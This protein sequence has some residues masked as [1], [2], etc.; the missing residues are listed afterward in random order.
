MAKYRKIPMRASNI[1]DFLYQ[2][3]DPQDGTVVSNDFNIKDTQNHPATPLNSAINIGPDFGGNPDFFSSNIVQ[4]P[5]LLQNMFDGKY[6]TCYRLAGHA[7][8]GS[9][10]F[11]NN[12]NFCQFTYDFGRPINPRQVKITTTC[13]GPFSFQF[14]FLNDLNQPNLTYE[15][16]LPGFGDPDFVGGSLPYYNNILVQD[17]GTWFAGIVTPF[18][19]DTFNNPWNYGRDPLL[20]PAQL[21]FPGTMRLVDDFGTSVQNLSQHVK[22]FGGH[23]HATRPM[24]DGFYDGYQFMMIRLLGG[25]SANAILNN[26]SVGYGNETDIVGIEVFEEVFEKDFNVEFDDALLDLHGW[27]NTRYYG[28]KLTSRRINKFTTSG[29]NTLVAKGRFDG[30]DDLDELADIFI[31]NNGQFQDKGVTQGMLLKNVSTGEMETIKNVLSQTELQTRS[32]F[33]ENFQAQFTGQGGDGTQERNLYEI[34][35]KTNYPDWKGDTSF[36]KN[37]V[38]ENQTTALYI[39]NTVV[40][41]KEDEQFAT[42]KGH[43]YVGINKILL[44]NKRDNTVQILDKEAEGFDEFN[45]FITKDFPAGSSANCKVIDESIANNLKSEYHVKMNKG[46]LLKSFNYKFNGQIEPDENGVNG[47]GQT[48]DVALTKNTM[49]L[50]KRAYRTFDLQSSQGMSPVDDANLVGENFHMWGVDQTQTEGVINSGAPFS[51]PID[52]TQDP[53]VH[54]NLGNE[55][56][57]FTFASIIDNEDIF[58][59]DTNLEGPEDLLPNIGPMFNSSS[60]IK[61][62]Y[63]T[64]FHTRRFGF[65]NDEVESGG[66]ASFTNTIYGQTV[67][68][69]CSSSLNYSIENDVELYC[70]FLEGDKDFAPGTN[71]ERSISTFQID[72]QRTLDKLRFST[73]EAHLPGANTIP[74]LNELTFKGKRDPKFLPTINPFFTFSTTQYYSAGWLDSSGTGAP[75]TVKIPSDNFP[76]EVF[77]IVTSLFGYFTLNPF[78]PEENE[79][80]G[81]CYL[82]AGNNGQNYQVGFSPGYVLNQTQALLEGTTNV[83]FK[84]ENFYS[85]SIEAKFGKTGCEAFQ[86]DISFLDRDHTLIMDIDKPTELFDGI[87]DQGLVIIPEFLDRDIR[88]NVEFYLQKAGIVEATTS[89]TSPPSPDL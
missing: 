13:F 29:S 27:R 81:S 14:Y 62:K 49:F 33:N 8:D 35:K 22:G 77:P 31:D 54:D 9:S 12:D 84:P 78:N 37:P 41:G 47:F 70:T 46:Y 69:L 30:I 79:V 2:F 16:N 34:Y 36:G 85:G 51:G 3:I 25:D 86:Y 50:Y 7:N 28:S 65:L 55:E 19:G 67:E 68:F 87:G 4:S 48:S 58:E 10:Y 52:L 56:L 80:S 60:I 5:N 44:I 73:A 64:D 39:A 18:N 75:Y 66:V 72:P 11:D 26:P 71:D 17:D 23:N 83:S 61:N 32:G 59:A 53:G 43:S 42:I 74:K 45:R 20:N 82:M 40:G 6:S 88:K 63:T 38:I 15:E 76:T 21:G 1:L 89:T 24:K 57:C